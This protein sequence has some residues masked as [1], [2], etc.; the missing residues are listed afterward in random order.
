MQRRYSG[1]TER[2]SVPGHLASGRLPRISLSSCPTLN[3]LHFLGA[4][5]FSRRKSQVRHP[6]QVCYRPWHPNEATLVAVFTEDF[7]NGQASVEPHLVTSGLVVEAMGQ[8]VSAFM[9][10]LANR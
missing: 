2:E 4:R 9:L 10:R 1:L 8:T 5:E 6:H 7:E 3:H